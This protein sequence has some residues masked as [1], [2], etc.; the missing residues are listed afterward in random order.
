MMIEDRINVGSNTA[1][2]YT[3]R[4]P[5]DYEFRIYRTGASSYVK[6]SFYSYGSWGGNN[7]SFEVNNEGNI[8]IELDK[9]SYL[10][11][12]SLKAHFTTPFSGKM[13]VT[14]ET[15][16]V[17]SYQYV[18]VSKRDAS[19][20][21]KL[22]GDHVPNVYITATLIKPHEASDIPLTVAHGFKNI[23]VEDKSRKITVEIEAKKTVRSKTHQKVTVKA[24][25]G[26]FVTL[27]AVDNGV[28]QISDFKTPDPYDYFYQKKALQVSA[29][30]L[31][32]LL[33]AEIRAKLSSTGGDADAEMAKRVNPM[34]AKRIKV[35][36]YW[37][38]IKKANGSGV[39]EFEFDIPQFSGELK[40][41][42]VSYKGQSFGAAD[43]TMIVADTIVVSTGLPRF[44][45]PGDTVNVPVT[46]TNTTDK[47][48][49]VT[50]NIS[51]QGPMKV[52]GGNNQ[53]VNLAAKSEGRATFKI[54]ADPTIN[55]G[56]VIMTINGIGEKFTD[57]T[58]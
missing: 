23:T 37:G 19:V 18:D 36:S 41:M 3:Q 38:G 33:F 47:A 57:T 43:N 46:L 13:L 34:P 58:E 40:L 15:D 44:L 35:V 8:E 11:G 31:Y 51:V 12:E 22:D 28:L 52:V 6:R 2:N 9:K 56:K 48:A 29:F 26:S 21:L 49:N 16:H 5:G 50:A 55:I 32:P 1:Y 39:A 4:S 17:L 7:N 24:A 27:S 45:S 30:D 10:A 42:A 54:V 25:P 53:S 14:M 20:E